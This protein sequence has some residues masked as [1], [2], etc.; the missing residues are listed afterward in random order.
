MYKVIGADQKEYGPVTAEQ[1]RQWITEGRVSLQTQVLPE[2]ATEWK[3][4]GDLP[5]FAAASPGAVPAMR[6]MP[7]PSSAGAELVRGPAIGLIVVA[8]LG[9]LLQIISLIFN[10][11]GASF[12]ENSQMPKEAWA[13]MFSGTIGVVSNI[14]GILVSGVILLG[15]LKMKKLESY[16]L[17]MTASII[18]MIPCFSPCCLLG[19]PI[20]IWAL[21]VLSKPEVKNAFH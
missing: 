19:L 11:A 20:G 21:V 18:A 1:L 15:G 9:V 3:A 2:G 7:A 13:N 5:E 17:A 4:L 16:G 10:L 14:I 8:I 6:A 12:L